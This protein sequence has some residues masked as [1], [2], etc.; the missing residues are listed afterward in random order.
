MISVPAVIVPMASAHFRM[1]RPGLVIIATK[2]STVSI[3]T[4]YVQ[5]VMTAIIARAINPSLQPLANMAPVVSGQG[6]QMGLPAPKMTIASLGTARRTSVRPLMAPAS[7]LNT[8]ITTITAPAID[9]G[10]MGIGIPG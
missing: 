1:A 4:A 9:V 8:A 2:M 6:C 5:T 7:L 10:V 3:I